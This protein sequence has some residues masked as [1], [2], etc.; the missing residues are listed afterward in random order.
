MQLN[1]VLCL[2]HVVCLVL[3]F[4]WEWRHCL[5]SYFDWSALWHHVTSLQG[6][7]PKMMSLP[8]ST[9]W[10]DDFVFSGTFC[11]RGECFNVFCF[12]SWKKYVFTISNKTS[13]PLLHWLAMEFLLRDN[14]RSHDP[15]P[16]DIIF[17]ILICKMYMWRLS[18]GPSPLNINHSMTHQ[19]PYC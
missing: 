5:L 17:N 10:C 12:F 2:F 3:W 9:L 14:I 13:W 11:S 18:N 8:Q 6:R 16:V 7:E 4:P 1:K 15:M 19:T